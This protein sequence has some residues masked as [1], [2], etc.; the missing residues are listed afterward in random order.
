M[1]TPTILPGVYHSPNE[2]PEAPER[3]IFILPSS[4]PLARAQPPT[5]LTSAIIDA[6]GIS[7]LLGALLETSGLTVTQAAERLGFSRNSVRMYTSGL[8]P[9]PTLKTFC[10]MIELFGARVWIEYPKKAGK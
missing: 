8:R 2:E 9:N 3:A 4:P 1:D 7:R 5:S 10:R 6:D